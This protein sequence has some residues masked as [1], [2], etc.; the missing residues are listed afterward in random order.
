M[1]AI[2]ECEQPD[3]LI[4]L[5]REAL[6]F[7]HLVTDGRTNRFQGAFMLVGAA[8]G[9]ILFVPMVD[10]AQV[11]AA[12]VGALGGMIVG[13]FASGFIL[14]FCKLP[15]RPSRV[16]R[17]DE[18]KRRLERR[19]H[20]SQVLTPTALVASILLYVAAS[21]AVVKRWPIEFELLTAFFIVF[22]FLGSLA[23]EV[24][25]TRRVLK[26]LLDDY[27]STQDTAIM[28]ER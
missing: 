22:L 1:N 17:V 24:N 7:G 18:A 25:R 9:A 15:E 8:I 28:K 27:D 3:D 5:P 14:M 26:E 13:A 11:L 16:I 20:L 10:E 4:E 12:L 19:Q 23:R 21:V 2:D 6:M